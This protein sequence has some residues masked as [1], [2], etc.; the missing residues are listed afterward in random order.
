M[1]FTSFLLFQY[2]ID[3][4]NGIFT[5]HS[6]QPDKTHLRLSDVHLTS[7]NLTHPSS[8]VLSA[9]SF[10]D[11]LSESRKILE[12]APS[13]EV[14]TVLDNN[15]CLQSWE[16]IRFI[17]DPLLQAVQHPPLTILGGNGKD[18]RGLLWF[19]LPSE[20]C[21]TMEGA[22]N[23]S[24]AMAVPFTPKDYSNPTQ[25]NQGHT[26]PLHEKHGSMR[27]GVTDRRSEKLSK[28]RSL[29]L[30]KLALKFCG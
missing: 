16:Y 5:H 28:G 14:V 8:S 6:H 19:V 1:I 9:P 18:M 15:A 21:L 25:A 26:H 27:S 30:S 3:I 23:F 10:S 17:F 20:V 11:I 24:Q 12:E 2:L 22:E 7:G 13:Y 4:E 29:S